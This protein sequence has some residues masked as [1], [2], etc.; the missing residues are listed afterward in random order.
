MIAGYAQ[1][2]SS[3]RTTAIALGFFAEAKLALRLRRAMASEERNW[4]RL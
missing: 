1:V 3:A 2:Y 4:P